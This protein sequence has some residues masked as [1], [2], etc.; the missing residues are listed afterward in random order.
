MPG[1]SSIQERLNGLFRPIFLIVTGAYYFAQTLVMEPL[2]L[3]KKGLTPLRYTSFATLWMKYGKSM[4]EEMPPQLLDMMRT[5]HGVVLDVG[6]GSG[7]QLHHFDPTKIEKCYGV[8]PAKELHPGLRKAAIRV[9]FGVRGEGSGREGCG[10]Y[11]VISAGAEQEE[12]IPALA[13]T[14][15]LGASGASGGVFDEIVCVRVLCGVPN[16]AETIQGLYRLLKPGGRMV[17]C[18][19]VLQQYNL[20][21]RVMQI[22]Y[23]LLGWSF[24]MGGCCLNR[25]TARVLRDAAG[26]DGWKEV[27]LDVLQ[28]WAAIPYIVGHLIKQS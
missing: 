28:S 8:E 3:P 23:M 21:A 11:V 5:V 18:E 15:L 24:F 13:K 9:G 16:H 7:E 20:L 4:S 25:D 14:G 19:H 17:I 22:A 2:L 12:L 6:P 1:P 27:K 26:K 10:E